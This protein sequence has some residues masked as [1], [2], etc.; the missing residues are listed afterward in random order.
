M[1]WYLLSND[2]PPRCGSCGHLLMV[3]HIQVQCPILQDQDIR[4]KYFAVSS[5]QE[6]F[7]SVDNLT[8][9]DFIRETHFYHQV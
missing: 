7:Q 4:G 2:D 9:I 1:H 3:K 8:V 5:V 6:S